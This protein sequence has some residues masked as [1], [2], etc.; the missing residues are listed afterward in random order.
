MITLLTTIALSFFL[1]YTGSH[2]TLVSWGVRN[3]NAIITGV[4]FGIVV[5]LFATLA[6]S[7]LVKL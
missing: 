3:R 1:G 5:A 7:Q 2:Y 6:V 4:I